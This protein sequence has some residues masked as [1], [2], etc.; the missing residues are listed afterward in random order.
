MANGKKSALRCILNIFL[1]FRFKRIVYLI[2]NISKILLIFQTIISQV[3]INITYI[4]IEFAV[5]KTVN[6][7]LFE[8]LQNSAS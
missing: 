7:K 8:I 5:G 6:I 4:Y 1:V 3:Y 2:L